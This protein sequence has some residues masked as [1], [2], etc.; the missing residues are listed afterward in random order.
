[1]LSI[2]NQ[3]TFLIYRRY[4]YCLRQQKIQLGE[5]FCD[6]EPASHV[7]STDKIDLHQLE[8]PRLVKSCRFCANHRVFITNIFKQQQLLQQQTM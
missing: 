3:E 8:G 6:Y 1:M 4:Q 7:D 5:T 2:D